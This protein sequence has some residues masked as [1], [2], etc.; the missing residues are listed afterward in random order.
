MKKICILTVLLLLLTTP[1]FAMAL[2]IEPAT[3]F[4]EVDKNGM[5]LKFQEILTDLKEYGFGGS[6]DLRVDDFKGYTVNVQEL[7]NS[8]YGN[9]AEELALKK[10]EI[11]ADFL[12]S[13]FMKKG[14]ELRDELFASVKQSET[15]QTVSERMDIS[16]VWDK[17][18]EGL[19]SAAS[20]FT[21]S[22]R[23]DAI[24]KGEKANSSD[25]DY[26]AQIRNG[27]LDLFTES[28]QTLGKSS[29]DSFWK[30]VEDVQKLIGTDESDVDSILDSI[31]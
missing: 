10:P 23:S 1:T 16:S 30:A 6:K 12:M 27:S 21:N 19:P 9:L 13:D 31:K 18:Q 11:P 26:L 25:Q 3:N 29:K 17:A 28:G 5:D 8:T 24:T 2:G 22:F 20:L 14:M 7:F 15:Y 4:F